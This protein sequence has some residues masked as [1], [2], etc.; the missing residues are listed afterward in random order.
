MHLEKSLSYLK[1]SKIRQLKKNG[2]VSNIF[3]FSA[4]YAI[5]KPFWH[6]LMLEVNKAMFMDY[7]DSDPVAEVRRNRELLLE[8]YGGIDGLHKHMD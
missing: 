2:G 5:I 7:I 4:L 8:I 3:P 6:C 1:T